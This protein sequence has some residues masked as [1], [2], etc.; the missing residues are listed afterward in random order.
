MVSFPARGT[1]E[2]EARGC[3]GRLCVEPLGSGSCASHMSGMTIDGVAHLAGERLILSLSKDAG[4]GREALSTASCFDRLSMRPV[5][6]VVV[7]F[8]E[9]SRV[10]WGRVSGIGIVSHT[11]A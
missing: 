10:A 2:R 6:G 4:A 7:S 9:V 3:V 11:R 5:G 1:R 8:W